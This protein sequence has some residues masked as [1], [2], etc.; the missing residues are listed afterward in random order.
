MPTLLPE[1]GAG[2]HAGQLRLIQTQ[3]ANLDGCRFSA[4]IQLQ[5]QRAR[6]CMLCF[7]TQARSELVEWTAEGRMG[8]DTAELCVC[9]FPVSGI[10]RQIS[11][12]KCLSKVHRAFYNEIGTLRVTDLHISEQ[13]L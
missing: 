10:D 12:I 7:G 5:L 1:Y 9:H 3:A 13:L 11:R 8:V 4:G 2:C 6:F